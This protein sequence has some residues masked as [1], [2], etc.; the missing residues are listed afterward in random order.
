MRHRPV[1]LPVAAQVRSR[2]ERVAAFWRISSSHVTMGCSFRQ[3]YPACVPETAILCRQAKDLTMIFPSRCLNVIALTTVLLLGSPAGAQ[4]ERVQKVQADRQQFASKKDWLYND[5]AAA[6]RQ[7]R[8]TG[9]PIMAVLRCIPCEECVKLDDDLI[10]NDPVVAPLMKQFILLRL[11]GTNGLDLKTFQYDTDQSFAV[12]FLNADKTV[13]GRFGTR[14]HRTEWLTDVSVQGM[15]RAM[16]KALQL[17][18]NYPANRSSLLAKSNQ[19]TLFST[20]EQFPTLRKKPGRLNWQGPNFADTVMKNCI[21]CHEI[22]E[23]RMEQYW[24]KNGPIPETVLYPYPHPRSIGLVLD[25]EH[26]ARVKNTTTNSAAERSGLQP[27]DDILQ[28][29]GQPLISM[30]DVQWV[31]HH[32]PPKGATVSMLVQREQATR[33]LTLRLANGWRRADDTSW[34]TGHW[35]LR[36]SMLGGMKLEQAEPSR[37]GD[38]PVLRVQYV[39]N[40]GPFGA[41]NRAGVKKG[42]V[43]VAVDRRTDLRRESDVFDYINENKRRGDSLQLSL[44]RGDRTVSA[45]FRIQ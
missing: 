26:A 30:A 37:T 20:P 16:Q 5:L 6:Y 31:L 23:A 21:H 32:L 14:S 25:P 34:R 13:Y 40:W 4:S 42:D 9:K 2:L 39:G 1:T 36:R 11:T 41:A 19:P 43:I 17:H 3:D 15:A 35:I 27:G 45:Q 10:H 33:L 12:F 24:Q 7:A 28:M 29:N 8:S 22:S 18:E 38:K 44:K